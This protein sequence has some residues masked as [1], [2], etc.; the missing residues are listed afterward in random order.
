MGALGMR[1]AFAVWENRIAP[2]FDA[3]QRIRI[4]DFDDGRVIRESEEPLEDEM[5]AGRALR[6]AELGVGTLIC[7]AISRPLEEMVAANGIRVVPFV[8]GDLRTL[9]D[10]WLSG[11]FDGALF[12][13]PG[14][15]RS[16]R[17]RRRGIRNAE[18]EVS[19]RGGGGMGH[20]G[21]MGGGGGRGQ[22]REG[23]GGRKGG[24]AGGPG[25]QCVCP[26]C[27]LKQPHERGV[28][29]AKVKCPKCGIVMT[30]E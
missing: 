4:V 16:D 5:P 2:V 8:S 12:S 23:R 24:A 22:G 20:G 17:R 6:L 27:G 1:T 30:R 26:Q 15:R 7:G 14:C 3:A 18:E 25:G 19:M 11:G 13:M 9:I 29:C 21:G 28:P 10:A